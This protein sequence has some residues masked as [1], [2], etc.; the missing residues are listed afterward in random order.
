MKATPTARKRAVGV[1]TIEPLC[2]ALISQYAALIA[3][4]RGDVAIIA[5]E[6]NV[7]PYESSV[8]AYES[9]VFDL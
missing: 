7:S 1:A 9:N 6:S 2:V 5:Y 3:S 8:L 4:K